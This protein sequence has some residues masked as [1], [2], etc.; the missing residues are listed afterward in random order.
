MIAS[1]ALV[2]A[3]AGG[4]AGRPGP[5]VPDAPG[6]WVVGDWVGGE[7]MLL[8]AS[9]ASAE[10]AADDVAVALAAARVA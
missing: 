5:R 6:V 4:T 2:T 9:L 7:G 3:A 8:D 1:N 10:R